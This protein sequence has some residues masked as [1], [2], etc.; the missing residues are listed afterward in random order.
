MFTSPKWYVPLS[1]AAEICLRV[2]CLSRA[3]T[4]SS[5]LIWLLSHRAV[6]MRSKIANL[7]PLVTSSLV[8][9]EYYFLV[10]F[11]F[12]QHMHL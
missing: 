12:R 9:F 6:T 10:H 8:R 1:F 4:V 5:V 3:S 7:S 11:L 2:C